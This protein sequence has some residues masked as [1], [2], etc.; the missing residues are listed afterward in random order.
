MNIRHK[1]YYVYHIELLFLSLFA[2][3]AIKYQLGKKFGHPYSKPTSNEGPFL[4]AL[5]LGLPGL[6]VDNFGIC[7]KQ[8]P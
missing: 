2:L 4:V 3:M 1:N 7:G 8:S 6:H 5:Y